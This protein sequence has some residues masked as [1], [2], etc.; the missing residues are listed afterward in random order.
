MINSAIGIIS[1]CHLALGASSALVLAGRS[2]GSAARRNLPSRLFSP[3]PLTDLVCPKR[4]HEG[5]ELTNTLLLTFIGWLGEMW[6]KGYTFYPLFGFT[7]NDQDSTK[8]QTPK[9]KEIPILIL[10]NLGHAAHLIEMGLTIRF[11]AQFFIRYIPSSKIYHI[12]PLLTW[13][14]LET[15]TALVSIVALHI[16]GLI[17][18]MLSKIAL[19]RLEEETPYINYFTR[20]FNFEVICGSVEQRLRT[21]FGKK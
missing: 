16:F 6:I 21:I 19:E 7:H 9:L 8:I 4:I 1:Q 5:R 17:S 12:H 15:D 13:R 3:G 14:Q 20:C 18:D 10:N 2:V 11:A